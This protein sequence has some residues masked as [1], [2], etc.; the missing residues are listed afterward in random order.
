MVNT[1]AKLIIWA[2]ACGI[3]SFREG[4]RTEFIRYGRNDAF[5]TGLSVLAYKTY[6]RDG[7]PGA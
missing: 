3:N 1:A 5:A 2:Q 7:S 6:L 4:K